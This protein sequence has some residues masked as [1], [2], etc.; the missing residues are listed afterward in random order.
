MGREIEG[1]DL[2]Y[3]GRPCRDITGR[4]FGRVRVLG[5]FGKDIN[6]IEWWRCRCGVCLREFDTRRDSLT[7]GHQGTCGGI[8][9]RGL[10]YKR[11]GRR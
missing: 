10:G 3:T 5:Y 2:R 8:G 1:V 9:C 11:S 7:R 4:E 6:S